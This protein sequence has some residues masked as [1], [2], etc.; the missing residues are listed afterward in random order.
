M[1]TLNNILSELNQRAIP[2]YVQKAKDKKS[3][4]DIPF[5]SKKDLLKSQLKY[6]PYGDF[7][8][9]AYSIKQIYRTSGT[10]AEPLLLAFSEEDIEFITDVG[11][12][13]YSYSGMGEVGN[14]EVVI[15]CLNLS[16]WAGGFLDS[17]SMLKT[18]AQ[19]INFGTGNTT[20][21]IKLVIKMSQTY[22]VSVHCTPSYLPAIKARLEKEFNMGPDELNIWKFYLGAEGGLQN[23]EFR[24]KLQSEWGC[25]VLNANYGMSE[26]C[27]IM[28][29]ANE[30]NI[31][32][33]SPL[34]LINYVNEVKLPSGEV[35]LLE[36]L[37]VGEEGELVVSSL[38]KQCQ[39][40][41]RYETKE[42]IRI[43]NISD[44]EIFFEIVGRKDDMIVVKGIN[45]FPEQVRAII[46][47]FVELTGAYKIQ[48]TKKDNL[49]T[50]LNLLCEINA[51][52]SSNN[53]D[54]KRR[55]IKAIRDELTVSMEVNFVYE[56]PLV[57]NKV[58][59]LDVI[60]EDT[61][62]K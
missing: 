32:R 62:T 50:H 46:T 15:N 30:N 22:K 36:T 38:R 40:V 5:T 23:N 18:G 33:F 11:A 61:C 17:Q 21:L 52:Q 47:K 49:I 31:L 45:F 26:V 42:N 24:N 37:K 39:P 10:T 27:S 29:S 60:E 58:K 3:F 43:V 2:Y 4:V 6:P 1:D 12:D 25:I 19:V 28:A 16:M 34:Y 55:I 54:L 8:D 48:A 59:V 41:I 53:D 35:C 44:G 14:Q 57:G 7:T 13:C 51:N 20:E 56:I 9:S